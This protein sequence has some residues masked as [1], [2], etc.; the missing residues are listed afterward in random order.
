MVKI[1]LIAV[2]LFIFVQDLKFRAV[3]WFLFPIVLGLSVWIG[4]ETSNVENMLFSLGFFVFSMGSLTLY[5]SLKQ[6]KLVN[7]S[8]G[9]F[10]WGDMLFL[11]AIIPLFPFHIYLVFFTVGTI[12]TLLVHGI[13]VSVSKGDATIPYAGYMALFLVVYLPFNLSVNRYILH[14]I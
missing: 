3:Y 5:M 14:F 8:K 6:K 11:L 10:S 12:T 1:I 2:L 9:Y 13:V 4:V 7:I